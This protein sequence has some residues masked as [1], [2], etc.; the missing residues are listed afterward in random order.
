MSNG[1]KDYVEVETFGGPPTGMY[2]YAGDTT[3]VVGGIDG[4]ASGKWEYMSISLYDQYGNRTLWSDYYGGVTHL[5]TLSA[6]EGGGHFRTI[7][8]SIVDTVRVLLDGEYTDSVAEANYASSYTTGVYL[9]TGTSGDAEASRHMIQIPD[10][11]D[12]V[13]LAP[14]S[15]GIP[16]GTDT[17]LIATMYD[18][19]GNHINA[20]STSQVYFDVLSGDGDLGAES[21]DEETGNIRC[22]YS[23]YEYDAD[24]SHV[25]AWLQEFTGRSR[26]ADT[27]TVFLSLIHI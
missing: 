25:Q 23:A 7:G 10:D 19:Y 13:V 22:V 21:V 15:M 14:D 24:T 12:S 2:I 17:V 11:P 27:V 5:V 4:Y 6:A 9:A 18:Q 8:G 16:A 26:P 3:T 20:S 1:T